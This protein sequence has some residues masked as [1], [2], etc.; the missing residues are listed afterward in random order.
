[1]RKLTIFAAVF[2]LILALL[3]AAGCGNNTTVKTPQGSAQTEEGG[4][5]GQIT[6]NQGGESATLGQSQT[7]PTE[8]ELGAPIYPGAEY[9]AENSGFVNYSNQG[10]SSVSGTAQFLTSDSYDSIVVWYRGKL[11][12]EGSNASNIV[13]WTIGD[14]VTGNYTIVQVEQGEPKTKISITHMAVSTK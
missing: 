3:L 8:A 9:D 12:N 11:G 10:A 13:Q 5:S 7:A 6:L 14:V 4:G 2:A 1:M